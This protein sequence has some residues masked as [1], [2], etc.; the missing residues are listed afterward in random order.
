LLEKFSLKINDFCQGA[1]GFEAGLSGSAPMILY[2]TS[3]YLF[4]KKKLLLDVCKTLLN[5]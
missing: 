2:K 3:L 4:V 5:L 1:K